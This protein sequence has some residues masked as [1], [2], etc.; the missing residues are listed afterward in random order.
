MS[1]RIGT[2]QNA[3]DSFCKE[4]RIARL[5]LFGSALTG[6]L[7]PESDIDVLAEFEP[8]ARVG[9]I[10]L[11]GLEIQL[12]ELLGRRVEIHTPR[13]LN[14]RF[15]REVLEQAETLYEHPG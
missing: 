13:G 5:R 4:H 6:R 10:E 9:L 7:R 2:S 8:N 12:G 15:R 1:A 3:I 11:A 14:P